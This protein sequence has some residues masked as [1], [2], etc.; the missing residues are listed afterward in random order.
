MENTRADF[1][2]KLSSELYDIITGHVRTLFDESYIDHM[3]GDMTVPADLVRKLSRYGFIKYTGLTAA[4]K[5]RF[6]NTLRMHL[7][8][9]SNVKYVGNFN[10]K[11]SL[12]KTLNQQLDIDIPK[13]NYKIIIVEDCEVCNDCK[14]EGIIKQNP[15]GLDDRCYECAGKGMV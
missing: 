7:A 6:K 10:D 4:E 1:T 5:T 13:G 2:D 12:T 15:S 9:L 8:S 14:D 11:N 3:I